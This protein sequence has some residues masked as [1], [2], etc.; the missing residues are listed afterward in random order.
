[1]ANQ[2]VSS[3]PSRA[4]NVDKEKKAARSGDGKSGKNE[5]RHS[6]EKVRRHPILN[7]IIIILIIILI[8]AAGAIALFTGVFGGPYIT[9]GNISLTKTS[10]LTGHDAILEEMKTLSQLQ[11][12]EYIYKLVFPHDY[13]IPGQS[14]EDLLSILKSGGPEPEDVLNPQELL[15]YRAYNLALDAGMQPNSGPYDFMVIT[16]KVE[17]GYD[18]ES[19][20]PTD[21]ITTTVDA[22]G[23]SVSTVNLPEARILN[24]IIEDPDSSNY[25]YPDLVLDQANWKRIA[26]F[27][28][29][30]LEGLPQ[31]EEAKRQAQISLSDFFSTFLNE[32]VNISAEFSTIEN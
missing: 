9:L 10:R 4:Q 27:V 13:F 23:N 3:K 20:N 12:V 14:Y 19:L 5:R 25:P 24:I 1:M 17:L 21:L 2:P 11:T 31:L 6:R 26:G 8:L 32:G 28:K 15:Y 18:L 30:N 29:V 7:R 22:E 16:A